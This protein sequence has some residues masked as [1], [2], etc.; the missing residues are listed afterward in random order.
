MIDRLVLHFM[1]AFY[2]I[3]IFDT[4]LDR[5]PSGVIFNNGMTWPATL[6]TSLFFAHFIAFV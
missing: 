2:T 1:E 6:L 4:I 5:K 3:F